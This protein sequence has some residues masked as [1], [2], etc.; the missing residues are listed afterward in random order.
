M[1]IYVTDISLSKV[2]KTCKGLPGYSNCVRDERRDNVILVHTTHYHRYHGVLDIE[3]IIEA[4]G[5]TII[6]NLA[7]YPLKTK[8]LDK[9]NVFRFPTKK[10]WQ[11]W[12]Y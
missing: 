5:G 9:S 4:A 1:I 11:W 2:R 12:F 6:K 10:T 7:D 3:S 8:G